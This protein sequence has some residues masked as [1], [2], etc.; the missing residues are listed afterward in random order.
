MYKQCCYSN[1]QCINSDKTVREQWHLLLNRKLG[2]SHKCVKAT[3]KKKGKRDV[4]FSDNV[5]SKPTLYPHFK[6]AAIDPKNA[7]IDPKNTKDSFLFLK[8]KCI[9][10]ARM[11]SIVALISHD[12]RESIIR[13]QSIAVIFFFFWSWMVMYLNLI[14]KPK[15]RHLRNYI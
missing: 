12:Y 15:V 10:L 6:N 5:E 13:N 2:L 7:T 11:H 9:D 8:I 14:G 3:K 4:G 1:K